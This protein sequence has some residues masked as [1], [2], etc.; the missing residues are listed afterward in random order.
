MAKNLKFSWYS[1][2]IPDFPAITSEYLKDG[3]DNAPD[4]T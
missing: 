3:S 2:E 1:S 4:L